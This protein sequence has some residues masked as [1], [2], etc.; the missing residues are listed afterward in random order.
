MV[1]IEEV[2]EEEEEVGDSGKKRV[3]VTGAG[4]YIG[5]WVVKAFL[6][7]GY[8]VTAIVRPKTFR[9][10][11]AVRYAL[12]DEDDSPHSHTDEHREKMAEEKDRVRLLAQW[13]AE[14]RVRIEGADITQAELPSQLFREVS[15]VV[16]CASPVVHNS[17]DPLR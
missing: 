15:V 7:A 5:H 3:L 16:H 11:L 13:M 14:G 4:G 6:D 17:D 1:H 9:A 12:G 10:I 8:E 2:L